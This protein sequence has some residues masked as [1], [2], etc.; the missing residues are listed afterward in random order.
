LGLVNGGADIM[1]SSRPFFAAGIL[2]GALH[3]LMG[4]ICA[5]GP[6]GTV[7]QFTVPKQGSMVADP[8]YYCWLPAD[9]GTARTLIVHQHGCTREY[10]AKQ[11]VTDLQWISLA[12]K[13]HAPFIAPALTTGSSCGNWSSIA[14]GSGDAF[15]MAL[16]TL[17]RRSGHPEIKTVPWALWGHSGGS[18][19]ITAMAGKYPARVAVGVA[20]ACGSEVSNI[21]EALKI[22]ILHHNGKNDICHNDTYFA[23]GRAKGA[24][25]AHAINPNPI[26]VTAPTAYSADVEGHA[27]H[28]MRMIAIPWIEAGLTARLPL[29]D[30][31]PL[32]PMDTSGAWL[33]D[34]TSFA[35]APEASFSGNKLAACWF[36]N[37]DFAKK[38]AEYMVKGTLNDTSPGPAPY[39]LTGTYAN[40]SITLKWDADADLESGIK[41]FIVYRNG[42]LH[43]TMT[44][45]GPTT[46][47]TTEKGFQ[48]WQ[49]GDQPSPTVAPAMTYTE[50]NLT[51]TDTYAY[52]VSIVNWSGVAGAKSAVLTL[53]NGQVTVGIESPLPSA[54]PVSRKSAVF[55]WNPG[56]CRADLSAGQV[57]IY[58]VKGGLLKTL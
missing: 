18:M 14:N 41:T 13:W 47:F 10:D 26:W 32:R 16:D 11:M 57:D 23:N 36:P 25:W 29:I 43:T 12:K 8:T 44:F 40:Q 45:N 31:S 15:L 54:R 39:N 17:A 34:K 55:C 53:K 56:A 19:W 28:D 42:A 48:R 5:S 50:A 35:I 7:Y 21:P 46:Y 9:M 2:A 37:Q 49:D 27:P 3:G 1:K 22:P 30:G 6:Q 38:W 20:Q 51:N 33:G 24:F 58:D 4:A 52:Q